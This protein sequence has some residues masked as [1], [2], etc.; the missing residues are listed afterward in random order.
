MRDM[1]DLYK[2][3]K[4]ISGGAADSKKP[5]DFVFGVLISVDPIKVQ[6]GKHT[7]EDEFLEIPAR[8]KYDTKEHRIDV[9]DCDSGGYIIIKPK[10]KKG[11]KVV[12]IKKHG[13]QRFLL[14]DKVVTE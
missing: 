1:N 7:L 14:L 8:F 6:W 9:I 11:D 4:K 12:M 13:G 3:M 2:T 5:A 10:I